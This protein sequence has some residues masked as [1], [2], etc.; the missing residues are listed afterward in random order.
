MLKSHLIGHTPQS[1]RKPR[2]QKANG[3][4]NQPCEIKTCTL[5]KSLFGE[6]K[7]L[8]WKLSHKFNIGTPLK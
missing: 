1:F 7:T 8:N 2:S 5:K 3:F 6:K 4:Q